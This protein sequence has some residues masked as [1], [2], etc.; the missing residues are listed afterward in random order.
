MLP[1][2]VPWARRRKVEWL[3][4]QY[5]EAL[6]EHPNAKMSFVGHS[7]GTYLLARALDDYPFLR[8][9]NVVL[10]GSV[11]R[12]DYDWVSK[13]KNGQ[14]ENVLNFVATFDWVVA[15]FP[16]AIEILN[17]QDLGGGGHDGF[18][19]IK[20][21]VKYIS[22]RH[23]AALAEENWDSIAEFILK[24]EKPRIPPNLLAKTRSWFFVSLAKIAPLLWLLAIAIVVL[25]GKAVW[26]ISANETVST[27][28]VVA[29]IL[30]IWSVI[31]RL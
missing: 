29:Y 5:A 10:A 6:A 20:D 16:K 22:G 15:V 31:T 9:K 14:I 19:K 26:S 2:V 13:K 4:D 18:D 23:D 3:M 28:L 8:F 17:L 25:I 24:G 1:F 30:I 27:L 7:N 21:E 12:S 11:V